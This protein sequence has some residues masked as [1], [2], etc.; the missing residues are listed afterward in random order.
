MKEWKVRQEVYRRLNDPT[1][2]NLNNID[3]TWSPE[4]IVEDALRHWDEEIDE[5]IYPAKSYFVAILYSYWISED[6]GDDFYEVLDDPDLLPGDPYF[7]PYGSD[8][9][10]YDEIL[11]QVEYIECGGMVNDVR[12]YYD[13]EMQV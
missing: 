10:I 4:S 2:D 11:S 1:S 12:K 13:E 9:A 5:W 7:V 6:F 8:K 3:I